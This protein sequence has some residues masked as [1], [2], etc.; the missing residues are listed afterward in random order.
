[1]LECSICD[2]IMRDVKLAGLHGLSDDGCVRMRIADFDG[3]L[4]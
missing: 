1:M 2:S 3:Y 4:Q